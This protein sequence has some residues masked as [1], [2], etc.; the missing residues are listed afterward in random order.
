[1]GGLTS[2]HYTA[3]VKDQ[4]DNWFHINDATV[5]PLDADQIVTKQYAD[6][7]PYDVAPCSL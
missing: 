3:Y 4:A 5:T 1:M 2:G 6:P 7:S